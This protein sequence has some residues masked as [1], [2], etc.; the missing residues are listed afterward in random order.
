MIEGGQLDEAVAHCQYILKTF[1]MHVDTYR[2]LGKAFL[3][4]RRYADAAD[5]F[6]RVLMAVP[7]DFVS[8]VGMSIIR[9]DENKMDDAIWHME[10]A[11]E[12]QPSNSAIQGELRRLYGRRDG[13]EP[14]KI[15]LSRDAL[16]NMYSQG[17]LFNQAIAEIR[18]VL[19]EDNNRP[20]LQVMLARAYYRS[21]QKVEAA[22]MAASLLKKYPYCMDSLRVLV[23]VLPGTARAEN[24]QVYRQRLHNLDPYSSFTVNSAFASDQ[25]VD[26]AV[27]LERLD[28]RSGPATASSQPDWASSLGI[29][30]NDEKNADTPPAWMETAQPPEQAPA[31]SPELPSPTDVRVVATA[32]DSVPDWMRSAGWQESNIAAQAGPTD[33]GESLPDEPIAKAD[34]PDWLKSMAPTEAA[35]EANPE[36]EVPAESLSVGEDG[37]PNWLKPTGSVDVAGQ[38]HLDVQPPSEPQPAST[39]DVPDSLKSM[40]PSGAAGEGSIQGHQPL[41]SQPE[42]IEPQSAGVDE[43]PDWLKSMAPAEAVD[44]APIEVSNQAADTQPMAVKSQPASVDETPD[45]LKS[46]AS[47]EEVNEAPVEAS[48]LPGQTQPVSVEPQ[49]A[50]IDETPDW[51]KSLDTAE[52][53][54]EAQTP[55]PLQPPVEPPQVPVVPQPVN[56]EEVPEWLKLLN[57]AEP[58][59]EAHVDAPV[60]PVEPQQ[61]AVTAQLVNAEEVPDWL[62]SLDT[63]ETIGDALKEPLVKPVEPQQESVAAQPVNAEEVPDWLKSL[64]TTDGTSDETQAEATIPPVESQQAPAG[65][66]PVGAEDIPDWLKSMAPVEAAEEGQPESLAQPVEPKQA[67]GQP[68]PVNEEEVPDWLTSLATSD[69]VGEAQ[70]DVQQPVDSIQAP[71][72]AQ[73]SSQA[74]VLDWLKSL[75][76]TEAAGAPPVEIPQSPVEST[77][78]SAEPVPASSGGVPDWF[79]SLA[80]A[81][82]V[83]EVSSEIVQSPDE[84]QPVGMDATPDWRKPLAPAAASMDVHVEAVQPPVEQQPETPDAIP[85]W[86]K[87]LAPAENV[88]VPNTVPEPAPV[89]TQAPKEPEAQPMPVETSPAKP[90][91]FPDWLEGVGARADAAAL[92]AKAMQQDHPVVN[93]PP[94]STSQVA[95]EPTV[96]PPAKPLV[97]QASTS[98][99]AF[100]PSGEVKPLSIGDDAFSWLES[101]AAKQGAKPEELL[102][103]PEDRSDEMPDWLRQPLEKPVDMPVPPAPAPIRIPAETL[104][105]EP[106][107]IIDAAP[108]SK[109]VQPIVEPLPA[110]DDVS[111]PVLPVETNAQPG[112]SLVSG[113]DDTLSWLEN[114]MAEKEEKSEEPLQAPVLDATETPDWIQKVQDDQ[115]AGTLPEE[116]IA[117]TPEP[118]PAQDDISITSWLSKMDVDEALEKKSGQIPSQA[119]PATPAEELP[120]WLKDLDKPA[121]PAEAPKADSDLPEWLRHPISSE[122]LESL[123]E[124]PASESIPEQ[125][126]PAWVD[127]NASLNDQALPTMPEEWLPA[128]TKAEDISAPSEPS[129]VEKPLMEPTP[130][131]E[132]VTPVESVPIPAPA[133]VRTPT[134]KQTGMLSHI[135]VLDKDAELLSSAQN[136]LDQNSLEEAMKKY[137]KLIKKGRLLD[138][139]IHDLR[140]AIYR[141]PVDVIIWQT[142]GDAYMR[143][144][145]L[146][147][148]LDSYTKAEELLR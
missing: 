103:K 39:G 104:P 127:E 73:Q 3:E 76:S 5:I 144:N 90:D 56:T 47:P 87:S 94:I 12:V 36:P 42:S 148:A 137:S 60:Q 129:S 8:H 138:E 132:P 58:V 111:T 21:G 50:S 121:P 52:S 118:A 4:A 74:D 34:I 117:A 44:Q 17:E 30:L 25:V 110:R 83:E 95:P 96:Q 88:G 6:E 51:L 41:E 146:Q 13:V 126:L 102:T 98:T 128:E 65:A 114:M 48:S 93:Q 10:R 69:A 2:L 82:A 141:Y 143:A 66:Q 37:I 15:R 136:I 31:A 40:T 57:T 130:S 9:D 91:A 32:A 22:E 97:S 38:A 133:P 80:D 75:D 92:T 20:D 81:K 86:L 55:T 71:V 79:K 24:T 119:A 122:G 106:L 134:L 101:L 70:A 59:N 61:S 135:P 123:P 78:A 49:P 120:D 140:E 113:Q 68:L 45:W 99:E 18:S 107:S 147:D 139:V 7:D 29:K 67:S 28:Y 85:D 46:M 125:E 115:L 35:E 26:S 63:A 77:P 54:G 64:D 84:P 124:A 23:D 89:E 43:T 11:F 116:I 14:S 109:P 142:L 1:P 53:V 105:L 19:V 16:A 27:N 131:A 145:R 72:E 33:S 112:N 62:N 108:V 100:Q